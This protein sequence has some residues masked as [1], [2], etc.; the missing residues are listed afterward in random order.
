MKINKRMVT[1]VFIVTTFLVCILGT[2]VHAESELKEL[3]SF[4]ISN[5]MKVWTIDFNK[6]MKSKT[7]NE[8]NVQVTDEE[9][10]V[11]STELR[12]NKGEKSGIIKPP[13]NGYQLGE[14]YKLTVYSGVKA[15][16]GSN[17]SQGIT[18]KFKLVESEI[19]S[20]YDIGEIEGLYEMFQDI[21]DPMKDEDNNNIESTFKAELAEDH[22]DAS[23]MEYITRRPINDNPW[24]DE[25]YQVLASRFEAGIVIDFNHDFRESIKMQGIKDAMYRDNLNRSAITDEMKRKLEKDKVVDQ[26]ARGVFRGLGIETSVE[27]IKRKVLRVDGSDIHKNIN[28]H[29][30]V[31]K[32]MGAYRESLKILIYTK[33]KKINIDPTNNKDWYKLFVD[34]AQEENVSHSMNNDLG[35]ASVV[36]QEKTAVYGKRRT[37]FGFYLTSFSYNDGI[38]ITMREFNN[39]LRDDEWNEKGYRVIDSFLTKLDVGLTVDELIKT[40]N[41]KWGQEFTVSFNGKELLFK[42]KTRNIVKVFIKK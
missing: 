40:L 34:I 16:G 12:Y 19:E 37:M 30:V 14:V 15:Q 32:G 24:I 2:S 35:Y 5:P 31:L 41:E 17:L 21:A 8:K 33:M 39:V 36:K 29:K 1:Q 28:G 18:F 7:F 20:A 23:I 9:G 10:R 22:E 13:S 6:V 38:T 3:E 25:E 11:I 4:K 26:V 27:D 42:Q